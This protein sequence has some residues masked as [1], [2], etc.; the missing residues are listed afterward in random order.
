[1][2]TELFPWLGKSPFW[3]LAW[4]RALL[5]MLAYHYPSLQSRDVC[6]NA[7]TE[8]QISLWQEAYPVLEQGS[9][10]HFQRFEAVL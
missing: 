3:P 6:M 2:M 1:M 8:G 7:N 9:P 4:S 5:R 10:V